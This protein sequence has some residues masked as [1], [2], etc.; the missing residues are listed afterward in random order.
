[1][2][3]RRGLDEHELTQD[4]LAS[5]R[6]EVLPEREAM[7]I[8]ATDPAGYPLPDGDLPPLIDDTGG[9][10]PGTGGGNVPPGV[11]DH[12]RGLPDTDAGGSETSPESVSSDDRSEQFTASDSASA[13]S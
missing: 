2:G 8:V 9:D 10:T 11:A 5:E 6:G 4:E 3:R 13:G 12:T 7:S 1:V